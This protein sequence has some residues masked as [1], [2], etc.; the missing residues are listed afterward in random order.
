M[1]ELLDQGVDPT[2]DYTT[3]G[4]TAH[5]DPFDGDAGPSED[6]HPWMDAALGTCPY[7][8]KTMDWMG[9][10]HCEMSGLYDGKQCSLCAG[11]GGWY[12]CDDC[13]LIVTLDQLTELMAT[14]D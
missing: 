5:F 3:Y 11:H 14:D 10:P 2:D 12:S 7:C 1:K 6:I 9:C 13:E 4:S 8:Y